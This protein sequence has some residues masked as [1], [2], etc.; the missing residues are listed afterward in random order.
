MGI[1]SEFEE[2]KKYP[3]DTTLEFKSSLEVQQWLEFDFIPPTKRNIQVLQKI[4]GHDK[5]GL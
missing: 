5:R 1:K 4:H 2:I 3:F